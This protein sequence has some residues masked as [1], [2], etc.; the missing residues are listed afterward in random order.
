MPGE[1]RSRA[2]G[3]EEEMNLSKAER[4]SGGAGQHGSG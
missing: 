1:H 2:S 4:Y 3:R